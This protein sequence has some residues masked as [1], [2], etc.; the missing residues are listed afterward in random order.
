MAEEV[1]I[2][3]RSL[4]FHHLGGME[5]VAWDLAVQLQVKGFKVTVVTTDFD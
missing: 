3:A 5:V 4:P 2:F 1:I